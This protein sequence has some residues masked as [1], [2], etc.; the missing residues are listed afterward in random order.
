MIFYLVKFDWS[1]VRA[2]VRTCQSVRVW[3]EWSCVPLLG[4]S[5][6]QF[7]QKFWFAFPAN[8]TAFLGISGKEDNF[9]RYTA[10]FGNL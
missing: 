5:F 1:F 6:L 3:G 9:A 2:C 7:D 10:I 8:G 4:T